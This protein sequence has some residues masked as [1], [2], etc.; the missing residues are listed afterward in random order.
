[1][2]TGYRL[3]DHKSRSWLLWLTSVRIAVGLSDLL[4]AG[5]MYALFL[6]FQHS[7]PAPRLLYLPKSTIGIAISAAGV[8]ILR[9][10]LDFLSTHSLVTCG[11]SLYT[12]LLHRLIRGYGNMQWVRFAQRS[13]SELLNHMTQT[14]RDAAGFYTATIE[15]GAAL[16]VVL[17]MTSVVIYRSPGAATAIAGV[18]AVFYGFHR[19]FIR[20]RLQSASTQREYSVRQ[21]N[22]SLAE[23]LSAGKEIRTVSNSH[24][25]YGRIDAQARQAALDHRQ[26]TFL[27][28]LA[29]ILGDQ[30]VVFAFLAVIIVVQLREG[31]AQQLLPILVFYFVLSRRLLPLIS[32]ISFLAGHVESF[33]A[34]ITLIT[35]ELEECARFSAPPKPVQL[36]ASGLVLELQ[37]LSFAFDTRVPVLRKVN[38]SQCNGEIVVLYGTSGS[39]KTSLLN[40]IAGITQPQ[41]GSVHVDSTSL[42][43]VPQETFL[44]DDSIRNNLLF[45]CSA[46]T[47]KELL[48]AL[49]VCGLGEFVASLPTGLDTQVGD[50]GVLLSGGQRQRLG[51]ARAVFRQ[52]TLLLLDEATSALDLS[53]ESRVL[54]NLQN[55]GSAVLLVTHRAHP[56]LSAHR[57]FELQHGVLI[58]RRVSQP[59]RDLHLS[60]VLSG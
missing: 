14:A 44:L 32:Q 33:S 46:T 54:G 57:M 11:Q 10:L 22:K 28:Q 17:A 58:E 20:R 6:V 23:M 56:T 37:S 36:P 55:T 5:I 18:A 52:P 4:L 24:F 41:T 15:L 49:D 31:D 42:A 34:S 29:R 21:L 48:Q 53:N 50:N 43:Y 30:G 3:L 26:T 2:R 38:L 59:V 9:S 25:F 40:I 1:V 16:V 47:D 7:S 13:R 8:L 19:V 60:V 51:L 12:Y 39:G 45:G 27:P 35:K